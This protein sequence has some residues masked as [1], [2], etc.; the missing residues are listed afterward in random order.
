MAWSA[1]SIKTAL[2][3][4][5]YA[6]YPADCGGGPVTTGLCLLGS[7]APVANGHFVAKS[8]Q[9][10]QPSTLYPVELNTRRALPAGEYRLYRDTGLDTRH[11]LGFTVIDGQVTQ[12]KTA[13][14]KF[15][16]TPG[17]YLKLQNFQAIADPAS[18]G[19]FAEIG[20]KGVHAVLPGKYQVNLVATL[21]NLV[22]KCEAKGMAF[23]V[24]AGQAVTLRPST[25]EQTL[26]PANTYEHPSHAISL[27]NIG[28]LRHDVS[29]LGFLP[30]FQYF[31][32]V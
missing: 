9:T 12:L 27:T 10:D 20:N 14:V 24:L 26:T 28:P 1:S 11:E 17:N 6:V 5:F 32:G 22:P 21:D 30:K 3:D 23:V 8:V 15:Q 29:K 25:A 13:T 16:D 2:A 31:R 18:K 7:T 4:A 19:C